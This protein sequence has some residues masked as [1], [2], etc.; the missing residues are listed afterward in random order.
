LTRILH[1]LRDLARGRVVEHDPTVIRAA[2]HVID[3][4]PGAGERAAR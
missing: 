4:G 1:R 2:D 3:L